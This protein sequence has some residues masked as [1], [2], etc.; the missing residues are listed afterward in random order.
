MLR[1]W[2]ALQRVMPRSVIADELASTISALRQ[3]AEVP[4][5]RT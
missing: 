1:A 3:I 2:I 5:D 4:C